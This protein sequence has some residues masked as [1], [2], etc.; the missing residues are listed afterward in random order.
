[1]TITPSHTPPNVVPNIGNIAVSYTN[2]TGLYMVVSSLAPTRQA[3]IPLTMPITG[4]STPRWSEHGPM[5]L[6]LGALGALLVSG[7]P[8]IRHAVSVRQL[9]DCLQS[10]LCGL[11]SHLTILLKVE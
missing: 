4:I 6:L 5:R 11:L 7:A 3:T 9:R 8:I 1:M 10:G 2:K